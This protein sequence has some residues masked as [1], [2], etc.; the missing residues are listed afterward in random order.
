[1]EG[2]VLVG[3][4]VCR[5][6]EVFCGVIAKGRL[7][8]GVVLLI[9]EVLSKSPGVLVTGFSLLLSVPHLLCVFEVTGEFAVS[10]DLDLFWPSSI[11]P[12][13]SQLLLDLSF[14][15]LYCLQGPL[16]LSLTFVGVLMWLIGVLICWNAVCV[17]SLG[18][19]VIDS[20]G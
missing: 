9:Q 1:M 17:V 8:V 18:E 13:S 4:T 16:L 20:F 15:I 3:V 14:F 11:L 7:D 19:V 12:K 10:P 5:L 2:L 6:E